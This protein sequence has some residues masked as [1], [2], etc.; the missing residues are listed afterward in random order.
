MP[1]NVTLPVAC[2]WNGPCLASGPRTHAPEPLGS[3][4]RQSVP[5][6]I[7]SMTAVAVAVVAGLAGASPSAAQSIT[8]PY[9]FVET[10]QG[11]YLY[12]GYVLTDR[13]TIGI[14]PGSGLAAGLGYTIRVSGPFAVD[15]RVAM[16]PTGRTVYDRQDEQVDPDLIQADPM[17]GLVD[18]G[19]ADLTL[20]MTDA[21]LRF[22]IT[23]PRTWNR[24][25]PYALIGLGAVF[26][27]AEDHTPEENIREDVDLRVRFR[28]GI[29]GHV[30]AGAEVFLGQRFVLRL[31]ARNLFWRIHVP[32]GFRTPDRVI[33]DR[34]WVQAPNLSVGV[35]FRF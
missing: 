22:N 32:V 14:G 30:G 7:R 8:S 5:V 15:G 9:D 34:E 19:T 1:V 26:R 33:D 20:L 16:L 21:S 17:V 27:T 29:T 24:I 6:S 23:G 31:D 10:S 3:G 12:G 11:I 4:R 35:G 2:V 13:G 25:Q 18:V 28:N